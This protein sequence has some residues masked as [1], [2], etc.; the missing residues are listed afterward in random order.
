MFII[1]RLYSLDMLTNVCY[2]FMDSNASSIIV[3]E[4]FKTL[5]QV[6]TIYSNIININELH[7]INYHF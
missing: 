2:T 1:N 5:S 3:H 6:Y 7:L 4:S